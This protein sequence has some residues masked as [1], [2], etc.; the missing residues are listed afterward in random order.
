MS[1]K[2]DIRFRILETTKIR[3]KYPERIPVI[4]KK[5]AGST[6]KDI[7]KNKYLVPNDMTL[8]QF[9]FIIRQR[10]KIEPDKALFVFINNVLPPLSS[11]MMSIYHD[12]KNEDGFLYIYY[13]SE[14]TFGMNLIN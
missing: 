4:V 8:S 2:K 9:I 5:A 13:N 6:L 14:S 3:E 7:N 12:M 10:I 1:I 11:T